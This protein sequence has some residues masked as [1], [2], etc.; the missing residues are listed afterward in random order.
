VE[1]AEQWNLSRFDTFA[2]TFRNFEI[3]AIDWWPFGRWFAR[4]RVRA[5]AFSTSHYFEKA[6]SKFVSSTHFSRTKVQY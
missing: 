4:L 3:L 6:L 2:M 1:V 5:G